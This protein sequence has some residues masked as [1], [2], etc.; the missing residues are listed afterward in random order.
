[1]Q[2]RYAEKL[3]NRDEVTVRVG[4][5]RKHGKVIGN[6]IEEGSGIYVDVLLDNGEFLRLIYHRQLD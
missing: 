1:M 3:H 6:P 5:E 4:K 2:R